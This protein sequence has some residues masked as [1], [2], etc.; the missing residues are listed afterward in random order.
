[1]KISRRQL[2]KLINETVN[3]S[4]H[5]KGVTAAIADIEKQY[6]KTDSGR[7]M[8]VIDSSS[9]NEL[10]NAWMQ[11]VMKNSA[12][13]ETL[14][15]VWDHL[16]NVDIKKRDNPEAILKTYLNDLNNDMSIAQGITFYGRKVSDNESYPDGDQIKAKI[17]AERVKRAQRAEDQK[18]APA[19]PWKRPDYGMGTRIDPDTGEE[20]AWT[21]KY[22]RFN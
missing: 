12:Y 18:N 11:F 21:G 14:L 20:I 8:A 1:M 15:H 6:G 2:R 19:P 17:E 9:S 22:E 3:E 5:D 16:T 7:K 4:S 10:S 13:Q